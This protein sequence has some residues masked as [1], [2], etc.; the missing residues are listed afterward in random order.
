MSLDSQCRNLHQKYFQRGKEVAFEESCVCKNSDRRDL[1]TKSADTACL[2]RTTAQQGIELKP[3]FCARFAL[4]G[5]LLQEWIQ[6]MY[7]YNIGHTALRKKG[8]VE[9]YRGTQRGS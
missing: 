2:E 4:V 6:M 3:L 9:G 7:G 8:F 1:T 5:R